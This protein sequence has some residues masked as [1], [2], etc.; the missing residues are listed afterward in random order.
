[1]AK[2]LKG[3]IRQRKKEHIGGVL[4]G[5][6]PEVGEGLRKQAKK[7]FGEKHSKQRAAHILKP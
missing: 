7:T 2:V 1:M 4:G 6:A 5:F 3:K